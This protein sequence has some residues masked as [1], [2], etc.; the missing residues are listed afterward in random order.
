MKGKEK[1]SCSLEEIDWCIMWKWFNSCWE[2]LT[3]LFRIR[4]PHYYLANTQINIVA[5]GGR[6][7]PST[8]F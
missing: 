4:K 5:D 7:M 8:F 6:S 2:E 3:Y 1:K